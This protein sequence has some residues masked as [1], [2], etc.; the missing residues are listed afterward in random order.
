MRSIKKYYKTQNKK[1][2]LKEE[3]GHGVIRKYSVTGK[4]KDFCIRILEPYG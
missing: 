2:L 4:G 1:E 3:K